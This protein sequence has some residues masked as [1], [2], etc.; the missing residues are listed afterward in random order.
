LFAALFFP[1]VLFVSAVVAAAFGDR[2]VALPQF[3]PPPA[4]RLGRNENLSRERGRKYSQSY[5][6]DAAA[7]AAARAKKGAS[8]RKR[9]FCVWA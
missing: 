3:R 6:T 2:N 8:K 1:A 7:H 9:P 5:K 4:L